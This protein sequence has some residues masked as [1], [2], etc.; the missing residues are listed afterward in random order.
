MEVVVVVVQIDFEWCLPKQ[1]LTE[2]IKQGQYIG[3]Y[4]IFNYYQSY[5]FEFWIWIV[6]SCQMTTI[7]KNSYIVLI[8]G[9]K[10]NCLRQ[11]LIFG[12][13]PNMIVPD[14]AKN[15]SLSLP[16]VY[17]LHCPIAAVTWYASFSISFSISKHMYMIQKWNLTYLLNL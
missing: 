3:I 16:R 5:L 1:G 14:V 11:L 10:I 4:H 15:H 2:I 12:Q 17:L 6:L 9:G 13:T 7:N 8:W